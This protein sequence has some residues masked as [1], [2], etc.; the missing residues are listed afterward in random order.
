M[1][2]SIARRTYNDCQKNGFWFHT[3]SGRSMGSGFTL[4][5]VEAW[6]L[7]PHWQIHLDN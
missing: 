1:A 3:G 2:R 4:E 5:V 7:V 6:V